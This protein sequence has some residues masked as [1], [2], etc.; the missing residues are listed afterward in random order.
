MA[1]TRIGYV[2]GD[3]GKLL[4]R[5]YRIQDLAKHA[6]YEEVVHLLLWDRLPDQGELEGL[7]KSLART[8]GLP[9]DVGAALKAL[10]AAAWPMDVL[11][12]AVPML[13]CD[14]P[15]VADPTKEA[16]RRSGLRLV[17]RLPTLVAAWARIR[18]GLR[19]LD[20]DPELGHAANF[21]YML[22][23]M[24]PE[25]DIAGILDLCLVLHAEHSLN[26]STFAAREVCST[27]AHMYA[28]IAAAAG[29]LSGDLHGGANA[30]VMHMLTDIG[31]LDAVKGY[32]RRTL[33]RGGRIMGMGHAVYRTRDP[34]AGILEDVAGRLVRRMG[35]PTWFELAKEVER[36]TQEIFRERKGREIHPNVDFFSAPVYHA[37]GIPVDLFTPVFAVSRIA[38][39]AAHVI[40]EQHAEASSEPVLYRPSSEYVGDYC[41]PGECEFVPL[42]RR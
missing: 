37:M 8:R 13:A 7:R 14:D 19:P 24:R 16:S 4:Y 38:G 23:G 36:T 22:T 34:R 20:P 6:T 3:A 11:Q 28:A 35:E 27:R 9:Y 21:L 42:E 17:A 1:S 31:S 15:D 18:K 12:A 29:S 40:E 26:A 39:W 25:V 5:G 32:V 30:R 33:D 2:D 41:G 10:P